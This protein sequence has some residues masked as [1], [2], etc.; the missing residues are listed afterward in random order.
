MCYSTS[1]SHLR[2]IFVDDTDP[3]N[4]EIFFYFPKALF[5][6]LFSILSYISY[7]IKHLIRH[8]FLL[9]LYLSDSFNAIN[10][11]LKF[12]FILIIWLIFDSIYECPLFLF[13]LSVCYKYFAISRSIFTWIWIKY[14]SSIYL[15]S[16]NNISHSLWRNS[17]RNW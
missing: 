8:L 3:I 1:S 11:C 13:F 16:V 15:L 12:I 10:I 4:Q 6:F 17:P 5:I 2:N 14:Q 9:Y 7:G